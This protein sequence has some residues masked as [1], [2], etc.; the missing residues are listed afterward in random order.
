[1]IVKNEAAL[2]PR[3]LASVVDVV[4]ELVVVDT[5]STD[6]TR[7]IAANF[8]AR[9]STFAWCD[10]FA[11]ARN[12]SL[13]LATGDWVLVLDADEVL[14]PGGGAAITHAIAEADA[15]GHAGMTVLLDSVTR[16]G[17]ELIT[18]TLPLLRLLRNRPQVRFA[19][20]VHEQASA[21][22]LANGWTIGASTARI[23]HDG[24]LPERVA[25]LG[26]HER[27][28]ALVLAMRRDEPENAYA[29]YQHGKTLAAMSRYDDAIQPFTDALALLEAEPDPT[30]T[31][32]YGR[33]FL[34]LGLLHE[35]RGDDA[36]ALEAYFA[37][38]ERIPTDAALW[39]AI[40]R[41][42]ATHGE[43]A[44]AAGAFAQAI[45]HG[46]RWAGGVAYQAALAAGQHR[47]TCGDTAGAAPLLAQACAW[48]PTTSAEAFEACGAVYAELGRT[49]DAIGAAR[50][51]LDRQPASTPA[52]LLLG[53]LLFERHDYA[54]SRAVL[55]P[56]AARRPELAD[57]RR[58]VAACDAA[59][60]GE[61]R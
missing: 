54:G 34:H 49:D 40:G 45:E 36:A 1:M 50:E 3:C 21:S 16:V 58:L 4:D 6:D 41:L 23:V 56:L 25:A 30:A 59:L 7:S 2:L 33:T 9:V 20:R 57:V 55:A 17:G 53:A 31:P 29:A 28:L 13:A 43:S 61:P 47:V 60:S 11:A 22:I 15:V 48:A 38:T 8:G 12:A 51:A 27:N 44:L 52:A 19:G 39:L 10:D 24:Y 14:A 35:K 37:G 46:D 42:C 5:G 26:K 32:F 18:T